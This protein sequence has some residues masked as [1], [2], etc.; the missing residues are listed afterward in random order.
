V[1]A[2]CLL[3]VAA[4]G[5]GAQ[6]IKELPITPHRQNTEVWCWG[7]AI[8][9][10]VDYI[11]V[12][13]V[14]D[15]QVLAEYDMRLGGMGL[16]CAGQAT[17]QRTGQGTEMATILGDI[18][19]VHGEYKQTPVA[20]SDIVSEIDQGRPL[21][22]GLRQPNGSGHVVVISGYRA[23]GEV[24]VLD[25]MFGKAVVPYV[26]LRENWQYGRWT[27]T[28]VITSNRPTPAQQLKSPYPRGRGRR[29]W[30]ACRHPVPR[31]R[32]RG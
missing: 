16:C 25:P 8:A 17:C 6:S 26:A 7:A 19:G 11:Q 5:G 2:T 14:E 29:G 32:P 12:F 9:M 15:C 22:A 23:Q 13:P 24:V 3:V 27:E 31:R 20:Y 18:F 1:L 28:F 10:V 30:R 4:T 21:I